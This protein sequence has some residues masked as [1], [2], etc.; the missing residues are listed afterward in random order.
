MGLKSWVRGQE[1]AI[2]RQTA[3]NFRQRRLWVLKISNFSSKFP[4][5]GFS[6]PIFFSFL[7][8]NCPTEENLGSG[9]GVI[10]AMTSL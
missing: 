7:E 8:E 1:V 10:P 4:E 9:E 5:N 3:A 6:A 2:F